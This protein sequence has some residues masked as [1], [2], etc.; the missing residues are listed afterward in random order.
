MFIIEKKLFH[1]AFSME[2]HSSHIFEKPII[3]IEKPSFSM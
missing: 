3:S 2:A 1:I